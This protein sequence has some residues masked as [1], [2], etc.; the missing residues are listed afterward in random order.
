MYSEEGGFFAN[1]ESLV[2]ERRPVPSTHPQCINMPDLL[3]GGN[4]PF[5]NPQMEQARFLLF[6]KLPTDGKSLD[7]CGL[8]KLRNAGLP[9]VASRRGGA[10]LSVFKGHRYL[11]VCAP[12]MPHARPGTTVLFQTKS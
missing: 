4:H 12:P 1:G 2:T 9:S 11:S 8:R 7:F 3:A 5:A 6:P 10:L